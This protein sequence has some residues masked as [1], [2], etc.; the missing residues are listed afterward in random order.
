MADLQDLAH[1]L[2]GTGKRAPKTKTIR[3]RKG[4][5]ACCPAHD[6]KSPSFSAWEGED[7]WLHF[8][9]H[10]G[11][12]E[13]S[14]LNALGWQSEDRQ[15]LNGKAWAEPVTY[16]TYRDA[17]NRYLFE[18]VRKRGPDGRKTFVQQIHD[19]KTGDIKFS[20]TGLGQM[21]KMLY[22]Y[23]QV[24]AAI[25]AGVTIYFNEGEKASDALISRGYVATCTP[26]GAGKDDEEN[27][28]KFTS[29]HA[30]L[31]AHA[32]VTIIADRD[33]VGEAYARYVAAELSEVADEVKVVQSKTTGD[34]D[35][36]YDHLTV[37]NFSIE[38]F[39]P[40]PDLLPQTAETLTWF[41]AIDIRET[42]YTW[43][44]YLPKGRSTLLDAE[45]GVG[46]TS[47]MMSMF[48]SLTKG[49][50]PNGDPMKRPLRCLV[51]GTEDEAEDTLLPRFIAFGGDPSMMAQD[52]CS[53]AL[54]DAGLAKL[55][56][57]IRRHKIDIVLI[58]PLFDY[59]PEDFSTNDARQTA[60]F[61]KRINDF[62]KAL[63]VTGIHIRH[64]VRPTKDRS[65]KDMG[66]GSVMWRAKHRSQLTMATHRDEPTMRILR[67]D[68]NNLGPTGRN[69]GFKWER[70]HFEWLFTHVLLENVG[71]EKAVVT[72]K[73]E[74]FLEELMGVSDW[75]SVNEIM[76]RGIERGVTW[77][78]LQKA[79]AIMG[80]DSFEAEGH[81]SWGF[82]GGYNPYEP[83]DKSPGN[84]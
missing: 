39:I 33:E 66:M 11:C 78:Q 43:E 62:Y 19:F 63:D 57:K 65:S 50:L 42:D 36:A 15:Y 49:R 77:R 44:P 31:L 27:K 83:N 21:S 4:L 17:E 68:K 5:I 82:A 47:V 67:H 59:L 24:A 28:G 61:M 26:S 70:D 2:A 23:A 72:D 76:R 52:S 46:K 51:L 81:Q 58:D 48:A 71:E 9:C 30:G 69:F 10:A 45:A 37:G 18:K 80:L 53:L 3:G 54:D 60:D 13:Q 12:S 6:D 84:S 25:K 55:E 74:A 40:R 73:A 22:N 1:K 16:Y 79:R 38:D 8:K 64:F 7:G 41:S 14:I 20:V 34:K 56:K 29:F 35:D 75:V 32:R